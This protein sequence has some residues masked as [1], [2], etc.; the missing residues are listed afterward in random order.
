MLKS[1][2]LCNKV[3]SY[4][5]LARLLCLCFFLCLIISLLPL[6]S[7][8]AASITLCLLVG[9]SCTHAHSLSLSTSLATCPLSFVWWLTSS[10]IREISA[11]LLNT[12]HCRID[13]N[14]GKQTCHMK[15]D[16]CMGCVGL[17]PLCRH[18]RNKQKWAGMMWQVKM[19]E[20]DF[21]SA[22]LCDSVRVSLNLTAL[23]VV[24]GLIILFCFLSI[25]KRKKRR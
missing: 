14:K 16:D 22:I 7:F 1:L 11:D 25:K 3:S 8:S 2:S 9:L 10:R 17:F 12:R 15:R 13:K 19:A 5:S 23:L 24:A 6:S 18:Q 4:L 21:L 20:V